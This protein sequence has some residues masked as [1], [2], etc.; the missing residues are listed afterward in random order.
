MMYRL[1][2]LLVLCIFFLNTILF[3]ASEIH[4]AKTHGGKSV[5]YP[6]GE[7]PL[8]TSD[9]T[10]SRLP[11][12]VGEKLGD[13]SGWD[14]EFYVQAWICSIVASMLVGTAGIFPLLLPI[15]EGPD[16]QKGGRCFAQN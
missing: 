2:E 12:D 10:E 11:D 8:T 13:K 5:P 6:S 1:H 15:H 9:V 16:L 4:R 3:C 14:D 7:I